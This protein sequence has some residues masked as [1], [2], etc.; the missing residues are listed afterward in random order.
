MSR[1]RRAF[2][3]SFKAQAAEA[4]VEEGRKSAGIAIRNDVA[5]LAIPIGRL[6][7][8]AFRRC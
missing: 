4:A 8:V 2:G 7:R 6:L 1:K 3:S 5:P